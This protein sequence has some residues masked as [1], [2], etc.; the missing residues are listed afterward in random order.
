MEEEWDMEGFYEGERVM[1]KGHQERRKV[2]REMIKKPEVQV[3]ELPEDP[4]LETQFPNA[5][6]GMVIETTSG[7]CKVSADGEMIDC[8]LRGI[9]QK[10]E[11]GYSNVVAVGDRVEISLDGDGSGV[12]EKVLP[13]RSVLSRTA[14]SSLGRASGQRQIVAANVDRVLIVVSWQKPQFWPEL[15]DRYLIAADRNQLEA[16]ICVNKIDLIE[17]QAEF[18][19]ALKPY[20]DLGYIVL[21]TSAEDKTGINIL[22]EFLSGE[23]TVLAGMS[24]VGKSSLLSAVQPGLNLKTLEVGERGKNKNQGRH[25]T[26]LASYYPLSG[27]GAVIDT[28]GIRDFDLTGL[29]REEIKSF[30]P[31][32]TKLSANCGFSDCLHLSE[33]DCAVRDGIEKGT[34]SQLRY[35][36][37]TKIIACMRE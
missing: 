17:D 9:L 35:E 8:F 12:I 19:S 10:Q 15:V 1:P 11:G 28:P 5:T 3:A 37:Y 20:R 2:V 22:R 31:E 24:G 7:R 16:V 13:R 34:V 27:G 33:P 4:S 23:I 30:Y 32:F 18:E 21:S 25:T 14:G 29:E 6:V 36:N 26:R